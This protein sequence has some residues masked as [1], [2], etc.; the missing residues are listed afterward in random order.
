MAKNQ[1]STFCL[2]PADASKGSV[3]A[4]KMGVF[5]ANPPTT[6]LSCSVS[7]TIYEEVCS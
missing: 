2:L 1:G 4:I 7:F 5:N 3:L 6:R